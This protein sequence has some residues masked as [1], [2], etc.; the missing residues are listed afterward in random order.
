MDDEQKVYGLVYEPDHSES[1]THSHEIYLIT[2][3]GRPLHTHGFCGITTLNVGHRHAYSG[4]T[5]PAPSGV[6]HT[7]LYSTITTLNDG[8]R[9]RISGRTGPAIPL[10]SGG[11]IHYFSGITTVD[12]RTPHTHTYSGTTGNER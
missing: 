1:D 6:P 3:D 7:H 8:H 12:G 2:W 4:F 9:H 10:P 11:H 5:Q